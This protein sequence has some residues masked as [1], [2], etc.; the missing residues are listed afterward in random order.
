MCVNVNDLSRS[1]PVMRWLKSNL[2]PVD[3]KS[4]AITTTLLSIISK[5]S[6][7][8]IFLG[9]YMGSGCCLSLGRLGYATDASWFISSNHDAAKRF[10]MENHKITFSHHKSL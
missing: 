7:I 3:R 10:K 6:S 4:C 5:T 1:L 9:I 2:Q 8:R